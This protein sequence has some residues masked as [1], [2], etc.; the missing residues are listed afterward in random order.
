MMKIV[1]FGSSSNFSLA[2]ASA[3]QKEF[4][5]AGIVDS[6]P[7]GS[8]GKRAALQGRRSV[9]GKFAKE[10]KIPYLYTLNGSSPETAEFLRSVGCE[11]ICVASMPG[12]LKENI[13]RLPARG[14]INA[15]PSKLPDYRGPDPNFWIFY[16]GEEEGGCTIHYIDA[17]E[18]TGGILAQACFRIPLEMSRGEYEETIRKLSPRLM[19]RVIQ[20][21]EEGTAA[22][23]PQ[24]H[25]EE[26]FR[27]R[28][29]AP[30]DYQIDFSTWD[31][32]RAYHFLNGTDCLDRIL[33]IPYKT[34][35]VTGFS[36]QSL[37]PESPKP[38]I[39]C[40]NG[41]VF[42][43]VSGSF[44]KTV[45]RLLAALGLYPAPAALS[46]KSTQQNN[47]V[48]INKK[49]PPPP[50]ELVY[51]D[52]NLPFAERFPLWNRER[53]AACVSPNPPASA[54]ERRGTGARV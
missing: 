43:R 52:G 34:V 22:P 45:K 4:S 8:T 18:D 7:R 23:R 26:L 21:I 28:R 13:I 12:L 44:R 3:I 20:K 36:Q 54:C 16:N 49:S 32:R 47:S 40:E 50:A 27:A 10:H 51:F 25:I 30:E 19:V 41:V 9:L 6:A 31:V 17:G 24:P 38:C 1:F 35:K 48:D 11:L 46:G 42:Y 33:Q 29:T 53:P 37:T 39:R 15:H 5:L 14:V 2:H